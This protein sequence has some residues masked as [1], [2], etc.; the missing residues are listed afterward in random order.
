MGLKRRLRFTLLTDMSVVVRSELEIQRQ[1][2]GLN[3]RVLHFQLL[4]SSQPK[5]KIIILFFSFISSA[6]LKRADLSMRKV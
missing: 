6:F 4:R 3:T 1:K 5:M 2:K